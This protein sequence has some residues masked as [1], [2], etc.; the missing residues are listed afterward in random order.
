M[1]WAGGVDCFSDRQKAIIR[2]LTPGEGALEKMEKEVVMAWYG[3]GC[4][5]SKFSRVWLEYFPPF[6]SLYAFGRVFSG[7]AFPDFGFLPLV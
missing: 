3:M 2:Y 7:L 4:G 5:R 6:L 1:A